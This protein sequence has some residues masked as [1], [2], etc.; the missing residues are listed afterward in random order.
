MHIFRGYHLEL[1]RYIWHRV[2]GRPSSI[3]RF[4]KRALAERVK[5]EVGD[6]VRHPPCA[7]PEYHHH[8]MNGG[9]TSIVGDFRVGGVNSPSLSLSSGMT[10]QPVSASPRDNQINNTSSSSGKE[11]LPMEVQMPSTL[12]AT[13]TTSTTVNKK[14][15]RS[16]PDAYDSGNGVAYS[17]SSSQNGESNSSNGGVVNGAMTTSSSSATLNNGNNGRVGPGRPRKSEMRDDN[18][19][20]YGPADGGDEEEVENSSFYLKLQNA[21]LASELYAYRRRIYLLER[22]REF[23]RKECRVAGRKIGELSGAWR[24]L[25]CAIGKELES[26]ALL[27]GVR[28]SRWITFY[29]CFHALVLC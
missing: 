11:T 2:V 14:R 25:E 7:P 9:V 3:F 24:G 29:I 20:N 22:E 5:Q 1:L 28:P 8:G 19:N 10:F 12:S 18:S 17:R 16:P 23:R 26:N 15:P 4:M 6:E 27:Q 21:S 13:D